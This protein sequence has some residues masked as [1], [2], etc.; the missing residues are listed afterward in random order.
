MALFLFQ[1][2]LVSAAKLLTLFI[3]SSIL[4]FCR[5]LNLSLMAVDQNILYGNSKTK[6][7]HISGYFFN[8][9]TSLFWVTQISAY[10]N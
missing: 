9:M 6:L 4:M 3:K 2:C 1:I 10:V 8:M 5:V 7:L